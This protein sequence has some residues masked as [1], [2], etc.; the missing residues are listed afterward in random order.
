MQVL[1]NHCSSVGLL[2]HLTPT[3]FCP[4]WVPVFTITAQADRAPIIIGTF[5]YLMRH[6]A[7][8]AFTFTE[9]LEHLGSIH[10]DRYA[11]TIPMH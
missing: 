11:D 3:P 4:F 6:L 1:P 7:R 2:G 5:I 10:R 8:K 9:P